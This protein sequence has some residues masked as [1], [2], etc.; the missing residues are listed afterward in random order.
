M[1]RVYSE[2]MFDE[3][4]IRRLENEED[5]EFYPFDVPPE[6]FQ[7][8]PAA[9]VWRAAGCR[10]RGRPRGTDWEATKPRWSLR[11]VRAQEVHL[12]R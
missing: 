2:D 6:A 7:Y 1:P 5:E 9:G 12:A 3:A 4:T 8:L 10:A 11:Y